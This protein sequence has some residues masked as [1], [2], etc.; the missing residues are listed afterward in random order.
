MG[1][2]A[3]S[4]PTPYAWGGGGGRS[5]T[6]DGLEVETLLRLCK[7]D[8]LERMQEGPLKIGRERLDAALAHRIGRR[9]KRTRR[10]LAHPQPPNGGQQQARCTLVR[11]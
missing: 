11:T 8:Q 9:R 3:G 4:P 2:H 5:R 7:H 10:V 1:V 6:H